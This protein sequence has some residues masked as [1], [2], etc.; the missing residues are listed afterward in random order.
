M[1]ITNYYCLS[2]GDKLNGRAL[3]LTMPGASQGST[4]S[5]AREMSNLEERGE[6][7]R[8]GNCWQ[9]KLKKDVAHFAWKYGIPKARRYGFSKYPQYEFERETVSDWEI[10]YEDQLHEKGW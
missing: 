9:R 5:A 3:N 2:E 10:K 6:V 7:K 4:L 1:D 8:K